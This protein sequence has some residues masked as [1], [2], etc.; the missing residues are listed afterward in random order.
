[1][2]LVEA[3][4]GAQALPGGPDG[5]QQVLQGDVQLGVLQGVVPEGPEQH[6]FSPLRASWGQKG[7]SSMRVSS[8]VS[9]RN[10]QK[11]TGIVHVAQ[12]LFLQENE[13]E[14]TK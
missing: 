14:Q 4:C 2:N 1:M 9:C 3:G 10:L 6:P 11:P 5:G 12:S 7:S 8:L 13:A